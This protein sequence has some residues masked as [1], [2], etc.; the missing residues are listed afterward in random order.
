MK[1]GTRLVKFQE[2]WNYDTYTG[3]WND[4]DK[5][6]TDEIRSEAN[7]L[8]GES[9]PYV[10]NLKD[11]TFWMPWTD[12]KANLGGVLGQCYDIQIV[13]DATGWYSDY[14]LRLDDDGTGTSKTEKGSSKH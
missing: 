11:G 3:P 8:L 12:T 10:S 2:P 9:V 4:K 6:W 1:N 5:R 7:K 13:E 14:F